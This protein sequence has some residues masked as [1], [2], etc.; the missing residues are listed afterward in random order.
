[1]LIYE[2]NKLS[3]P[4]LLLDGMGFSTSKSFHLIRICLVLCNKLYIQLTLG[5]IMLSCHGA[6]IFMKET[7]ICQIIEA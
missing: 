4:K 7:D 2:E 3:K 6:R 1:M 5:N